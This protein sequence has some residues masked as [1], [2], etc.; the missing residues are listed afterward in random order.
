MRDGDGARDGRASRPRSLLD[1]L[2]PDLH[3]AD[4]PADRLGQLGHELDDPRVLVGRRGLLDVLLQLGCQLGA[5]R[6]S[7][8]KDHGGLDHGAAVRIRHVR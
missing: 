5:C 6:I 2:L 8:G 1:V 4:L 3:P 7:L